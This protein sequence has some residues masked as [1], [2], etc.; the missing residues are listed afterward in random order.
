MTIMLNNISIND[1]IIIIGSSA[2]LCACMQIIL[3]ILISKCN[4]VWSKLPGFVAHHIVAFVLMCVLTFIG[5]D[6]WVVHREQYDKLLNGGSRLYI[7]T[8]PGRLIS[9]IML[10]S[11]IGWDLPVTWLLSS[12]YNPI[13]VIHHIIIIICAYIALTYSC[14][15]FYA[16]FFF[17]IIEISSIPLIIVDIFHPTR[18]YELTTRHICLQRT[19]QIAQALFF[20]LFIGARGFWWSIVIFTSFVPDIFYNTQRSIVV[21]TNIMFVLIMSCTILQYYWLFIIVRKV[22]HANMR[23]RFINQQMK[24]I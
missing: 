2:F 19:N 23:Q 9:C 22:W 11:Q 13:M 5:F 18:F 6:V 20:V 1:D 17:G 14:L 21:Q 15:I 24:C 10:G 3:T 7:S 16:P 12:L 8:G 4:T